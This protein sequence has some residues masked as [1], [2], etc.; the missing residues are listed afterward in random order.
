[1]RLDDADKVDVAMQWYASVPNQ[2]FEA[3]LGKC[4]KGTPNAWMVKV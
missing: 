4:G 3:R 2:V 1:V